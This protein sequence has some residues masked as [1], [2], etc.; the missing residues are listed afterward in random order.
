MILDVTLKNDAY[1]LKIHKNFFKNVSTPLSLFQADIPL[2]DKYS[3]LGL[4]HTDE[5]SFGFGGCFWQEAEDEEYRFYKFCFPKSFNDISMRQALL[6]IYL[7][8]YYV[9]EQMFYN[10]EFLTEPVWDDQ[11][12]T[13]VIWNGGEPS[14][15]YAIGGQVYPWFKKRLSSLSDNDLISLN[16]Y[17]ATELNRISNC[18]FKEDVSCMQVTIELE[19]FFIQVSRGGRWI[20][21]KKNRDLNKP[22]EF[23]SHNI[24]FSYDQT[25][26][27]TAM[28]AINTWLREN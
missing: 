26:C 23:D 15:G 24:D 13:F 19:S 6:S 25:L 28:V 10:K 14:C 7:A 9:V 4:F 8:T 20:S 12:L 17:V 21:W 1:F 3:N 22:E 27:F 18:F 5:Q 2:M 16:D 11:S